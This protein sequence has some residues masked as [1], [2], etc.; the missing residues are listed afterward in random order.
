MTNTGIQESLAQEY[1][2]GV[3]F[4]PMALRLLKN[5]VPFENLQITELKESMFQLGNGLWFCS[6]MILNKASLFEFREQADTWLTEYGFFSVEQLHIRFRDVLRHVD[7]PEYCAIFLQN[8]GYSVAVW[9]KK[10]CFCY[11][12]PLNLD[13]TLEETSETIAEWLDEADGTLTFHEIELSLPHL[14]AEALEAIRAQFLPEVYEME[15]GGV[16]CLRRADAISMPEGF[17]EKLSTIVDTLVE[18]NE[19]VTISKL[20]F[21]LNLFY[22]VKFRNLYALTDNNTFMR[23]CAKHYKGDND[24]FPGRKKFGVK[25]NDSS[26]SA[27]R[28]RSPNTLFRN[29]DVPIGAVLVFIKDN[30]IKCTV[31]DSSNQVDFD[32]KVW[33]ISALATHLLRGVAANGF[34]NF[35]Y[36]GEILW[37]RRMR[38]EQEKFVCENTSSVPEVGTNV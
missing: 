15:I 19:S 33:A 2:N 29:I 36:D 18:L 25:S 35:S 8:L 21:A 17:T 38:I 6:E 4:E 28:V 23:I 9:G 3:S 22:R 37:D 12:P 16:P 27:K 1:P 11:W 31:I 32:G 7:T 26:V 24:V 34:A 5:K 14:N 20:E 13:D 10:V 30:K